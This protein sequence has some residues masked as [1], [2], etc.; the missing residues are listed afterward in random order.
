MPMLWVRE[1]LGGLNTQRMPET[2]PG[3]VLLTAED[4]HITP[5]G[6]FESRAAFIDEYTLPAGTIGL[7]A[8]RSELVAFGSAVE[9]TMPAGVAYQRLQ[10]PDGVTTL[11]D[12]PSW[13]LYAGKIYVVG[14]FADGS[15]HHFYN[16]T[17]V[18]DWFDGRARAVFSVVN[19]AEN[20]ATAATGSFRITGGTNGVGNEITAITV[21]GVSVISGDIAH[22]GDDETTA[23]AVAANINGHTSSPNYTAVAAGDQVTITAATTGTGPN[24]Y[25]LVVTDAGDVVVTS[26]TNFSGGA[27]ASTS[28]LTNVQIDGVSVIAAPIEYDT[29]NPTTAEAIAAEITSDISE[30]EY[31]AIAFGD[32]V[33]ITA[34][35]AGTAA[36]GRP[37]VFT[38]ANG[39]VLDP[40][41]GLTLSGGA[42][43]D[44]AF[45]PGTFVR[46]IGSKMHALSGPNWHFSG[47]REPT[48]WTTDNVGAGFVDLS[49]HSSG[50]EQLTA[51]ARYQQQLAI[52]SE[53]M[54]QIW[55]SDPDPE[56]NTLVQIL[57]NTGTSAPRSVTQFGDADIFYLNESGVRSLRA[58]DASNSASTSDI[59]VPIDKLVTAALADLAP[60]DREKIT[61]LI[62]PRDGRFWLILGDTVFVLSY[63][64]TE[65]S[66]S[67]WS[68]Y[69]LPAEIDAAIT[70]NRKIWLRLGDSI[71]VYGGTGSAREYDATVATV[72][73]PFL[74]ADD[75]T[76]WK[77]LTAVDI[78]AEGEWEVFVSMDPTNPDVEDR[79]TILEGSSF[80]LQRIPLQ[81]STTH[82]SFTFKSRGVG[83]H[84]LGSLVVHFNSDQSGKDA[85]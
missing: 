20:A 74:D 25:V 2:T 51:I 35:T 80:R 14:I 28:T 1:F 78:A 8:T 43:S 59:G 52:F 56:L 29:D 41:S 67:A 72:R 19:G 55:F 47:I 26:V 38:V 57:N 37:V 33:V 10:H 16:G 5:G 61:G 46:T 85:G 18:E 73:T 24:G 63:F 4:G 45:T 36:N 71:Y 66:V 65:R 27:A 11:I 3:G 81:G 17:R 69:T 75:P 31:S 58:R 54:V 84:K 22:T 9:P 76:Q 34:E 82:M 62:E 21:N 30:P 7:A 64:R 49:T 77:H 68:T 53:T 60:A 44:E 23:T 13:D 42:D 40:A 70:F 6:E 32:T 79:V 12:V 48:G 39:L 50:A 83:P 15:R